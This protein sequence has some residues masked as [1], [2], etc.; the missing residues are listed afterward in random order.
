MGIPLMMTEVYGITKNEM[1]TK[2]ITTE[3]KADKTFYE[4]FEGALHYV[5]GLQ[6]DADKLTQQYLTG[7]MDNIHQVVLA[8]ERASIALQMTVQVRNKIVEAYQEISRMQI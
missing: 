3:K 4:V 6:K 7:D 8:V 1:A 5:D 2:N